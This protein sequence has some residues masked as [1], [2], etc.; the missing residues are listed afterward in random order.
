MR[1]TA[2]RLLGFVLLGLAAFVAAQALQWQIP[3]SY[4]PV[5]PRAFPLGLAL[6]LSILALVL[7]FRPGANGEWPHRALAMKLLM[8]LVLL[9]VYATLFTRLGYIPASLLAATLLAHLFGA[10]WGKALI[11]GSLM[12]IGS[13]FLF[14]SGLGISLPD[15]FLAGIV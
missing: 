7:V 15:G 14:T 2:D 10:T 13:Y 5:G 12:A 6:L 1:V 4:E 8:V 11:T 9:V 3:F